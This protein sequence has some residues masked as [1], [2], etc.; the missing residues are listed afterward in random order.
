MV[1]PMI[2]QFRTCRGFIK[3]SVPVSLLLA[4]IIIIIRRRDVGVAVERG[5]GLLLGWLGTPFLI[6]P[7]RQSIVLKGIVRLFVVFG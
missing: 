1:H 4:T 5:A 6:F 7:Q 2:G 3:A